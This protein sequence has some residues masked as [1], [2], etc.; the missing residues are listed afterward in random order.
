MV[1]RI[2]ETGTSVK[3]STPAGAL[4][5]GAAAAAGTKC[6]TSRLTMR[7]PSPEPGMVARLRPRSAA[8][9]F[10]N[11]EA[12]NRPFVAGAGAGATGAG[13]AAT[14]AGAGAATGT[15]A[16]VGD[17]AGAG[18]STA[19]ASAA[20]AGADAPAAI[21]ADTSSPSSPRMQSKESTGAVCPC[22]TP[23]CKRTPS[24]KDSNSIVALSVSISAKISP[25]STASP[26]FFNQLATT[27]SVMVSLSLGM[28]TISAISQYFEVLLL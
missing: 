8:N 10:A 26:T 5:T 17:G 12:F 24:K 19:G 15:G 11:G 16:G 27:P 2:C 28:R 9:F 7:P 23:M 22:S 25:L 6:S 21:K 1:L 3:D 18:A 4:A 13:A 20:G 14:G